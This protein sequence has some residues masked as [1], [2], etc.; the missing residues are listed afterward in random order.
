[1]QYNL[2][3]SCLWAALFCAPPIFLYKW[4]ESALPLELEDEL[5]LRD[6][7]LLPLD[8]RDEDDDDLLLDLLLELALLL[9]PFSL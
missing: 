6:D 7:L 3:F 9:R 2:P 5:R 8:D 4:S 1:M